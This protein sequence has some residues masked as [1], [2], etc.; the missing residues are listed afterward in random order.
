MLK[1]AIILL[2][3]SLVGLGA[4]T[5]SFADTSI[6]NNSSNAIS[7]T[8][9]GKGGSKTGTVPAGAQGMLSSNDTKAACG[10][11]LFNNQ[12]CSLKFSGNGAGADLTMNFANLK[13][14]ARVNSIQGLSATFNGQNV[15][16]GQ[17][18][19]MNL[20]AMNNLVINN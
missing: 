11:G 12:P 10:W 4:A 7:F 13:I 8:V 3:V 14:S 18:L 9:S 17:T 15:A 1:K 6:T 5:V 16:T 20:T 2:S 19:E